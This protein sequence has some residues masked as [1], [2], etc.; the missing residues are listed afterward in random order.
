MTTETQLRRRRH[1][2]QVALSHGQTPPESDHQEEHPRL[3][4][5]WHWK[6]AAF[7]LAIC[8]VLALTGIGLHFWA[9][10]EDPESPRAFPSPALKTHSTSEAEPRPSP[11]IVLHVTG[12]VHRPGVIRIEK[13]MRVADAIEQA[14][15]FTEEADRESINLARLVIDGEQIR[16]R[17]MKQ[18]QEAQADASAQ[19]GHPCVDLATAD[20]NAL[21][22]LDGVGPSLAGRI[23]AYRQ[24]HPI[25]RVDDLDAVPGIGPA[26]VEKIR[27]GACQ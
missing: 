10:V 18:G 1:L 25:S 11:Q 5:K 17:S 20:L 23:L 2:Q 4:W 7:F 9:V 13:G 24:T 15:G 19:N 22:N 8:T 27:I 3:R 16:V 6:T 14:G 12:E 26:L 21:Q